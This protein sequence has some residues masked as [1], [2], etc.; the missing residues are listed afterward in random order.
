M[1]STQLVESCNAVVRGFLKA[2]ISMI[3][4][5]PHFERMVDSRRRAEQGAEYAARNSVPSINFSYSPVV[6]RAATEYTPTLFAM[7]Q[8]QYGRIMEY[9]L[10]LVQ[11]SASSTTVSFIAYKMHDGQRLDD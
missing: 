2:N 5:F 4:F 11:G 3:D 9:R 1:V 6:S 8:E 10:E 7:F